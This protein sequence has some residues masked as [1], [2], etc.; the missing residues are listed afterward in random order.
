MDALRQQIEYYRARAGEYDEW[1]YRIGRYDQG[2]DLNRRWFDE[3]R[4]CMARLL[5]V[6]PVDTAL[7][8]AAGTGIWTRELLKIAGHVTAIDASPEVLAINRQKLGNPPNV[9]YEQADLFRWEAAQ[10]YDLVSFTFWLSHVPPAVVEDFLS[11]VY[12]T[13]KPGGTVFMVDS[14]K[15]PTST[16]H[17]QSVHVTGI[18]QQ[19]ILNDGRTFEIVKIYYDIHQLIALFERAGFS[20][21]AKETPAYFVYAAARR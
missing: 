4:I 8:L 1:F 2:P 17:N 7:E 9:S 6:G 20:V 18:Q 11:K 12:R 3:A 5:S 15:A 19:R 13:T 16:A 21:E 10:Q 14:K